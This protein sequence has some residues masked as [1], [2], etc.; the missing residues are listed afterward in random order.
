[1]FP[2]AIAGIAGEIDKPGLCLQ[3]EGTPERV[4]GVAG[5]AARPVAGRR[6]RYLDAVERMVLVKVHL[7]HMQGALGFVQNGTIAEWGEDERL[8]S[9]VNRFEGGQIHVVIVIVR[10]QHEVDFRQILQCHAGCARA[11]GACPLHGA[12]ALGEEG[13]GENV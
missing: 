11:L 10:Q 2:I 5:C 4:V 13:I 7:A 12:C 3:N 8:M 6:E 1:M 9:R